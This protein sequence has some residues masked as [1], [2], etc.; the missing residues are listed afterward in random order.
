[1]PRP[2][3]KHPRSEEW[4]PVTV[5][6]MIK[7]LGLIFLTGIVRKPKL[8][9]YWSREEFFGRQYFHKQCLGIDFNLSKGT[10][11]SVTIMQQEQTKIVCT[12]SVQL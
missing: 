4:K 3:T 8:E 6:E 5:I 12:K 7:F 10:F 1:M 11:T 9:L 2:V